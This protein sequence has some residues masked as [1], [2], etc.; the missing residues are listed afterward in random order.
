VRN[1]KKQFC[2][3]SCLRQQ[4]KILSEKHNLKDLSD[5]E[6]I[7][8][9]KEGGRAYEAVSEYLFHSLLGFVP[10]IKSKLNLSQAD[11]EDAYAD[12]LVK[13]LRQIKT[14]SFRGDSKIST[15]FFRIFNNTAVD[16]SRRNASNK[17][18]DTVEISPYDAKERDLLELIEVK[19]ETKILL[20]QIDQLGSSCKS[21]LLDWGYYGYNMEEIA[22]RSNLSGADSAR[23]M[24]F[25]CLKRLRNLISQQK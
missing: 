25:K 3:F 1:K 17:V 7:A 8:Q 23:S 9:V 19:S 20:A 6:I 13:L 12:S 21:I 2:L 16:V 10:Q 5:T 24:K 4:G 18:L 22:K 14:A 11:V 15:Y